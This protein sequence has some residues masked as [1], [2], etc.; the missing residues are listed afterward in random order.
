MLAMDHTLTSASSTQHNPAYY[1][2]LWLIIALSTLVGRA[3]YRPLRLHVPTRPDESVV[4]REVRCWCMYPTDGIFLLVLILT[5][6]EGLYDIL[7]GQLE[8]QA[9][10]TSLVVTAVIS[11]SYIMSDVLFLYSMRRR[12]SLRVKACIAGNIALVAVLG[13]L[14]VLVLARLASGKMSMSK[15]KMDAD[16]IA[17]TVVVWS[18]RAVVVGFLAWQCGLYLK[19]WQAYEDRQLEGVADE[20]GG[21]GWAAARVRCWTFVVAFSSS[22]LVTVLLVAAAMLNEEALWEA[23]TL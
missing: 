17:Y 13:V 18:L 21:G 14:L 1:W 23:L 10:W 2:A 8:T 6:L 11:L 7:E 20:D 5:A 4:E 3:L 15:K 19:L 9:N 22:A 12:A 16:E